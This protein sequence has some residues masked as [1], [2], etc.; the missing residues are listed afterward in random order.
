MGGD[1]EQNCTQERKVRGEHF[2]VLLV[3]K[4]K[5]KKKPAA[6]RS[7]PAPPISLKGKSA[8]GVQPESQG[9]SSLRKKEKEGTEDGLAA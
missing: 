5:K 3:G 8:T 7:S 6:R 2:V 4:K 1:D 9:R